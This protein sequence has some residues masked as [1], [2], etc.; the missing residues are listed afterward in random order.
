MH[1][2]PE[3]AMHKDELAYYPSHCLDRSFQNKGIVIQK[4]HVRRVLR[5]RPTA[6]EPSL[7]ERC[8]KNTVK[9]LQR[10]EAVAS[11]QDERPVPLSAV[12]TDCTV[13]GNLE[14]RHRDY[15]RGSDCVGHDSL[16]QTRIVAKMM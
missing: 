12:E 11:T 5:L 3:Q 8:A 13:K 6:R 14:L 9:S 2:P 15:C 7:I 16:R 4:G 10:D 1:G